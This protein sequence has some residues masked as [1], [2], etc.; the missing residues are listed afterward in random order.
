MKTELDEK[1][2]RL[3]SID[4]HGRWWDI[5]ESEMRG[6]PQRRRLPSRPLPP[7]WQFLATHRDLRSSGFLGSEG[8]KGRGFES[9]SEEAVHWVMWNGSGGT[10]LYAFLCRGTASIYANCAYGRVFCPYDTDVDVKSTNLILFNLQCTSLNVTRLT[11]ETSDGGY[12]VNAD[13]GPN[14]DGLL[15]WLC[16]CGKAR[17]TGLNESQPRLLSCSPLPSDGLGRRGAEAHRKQHPQ[18]CGVNPTAKTHRHTHTSCYLS[19][20][21]GQNYNHDSN[22]DGHQFHAGNREHR[23]GKKPI[24]TTTKSCTKNNNNKEKQSPSLK[25]S[26]EGGSRRQLGLGDAGLRRK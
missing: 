6:L 19:Y 24:T 20:L 23:R 26:A 14:F 9:D 22:N 15:R 16:Q 11:H 4:R 10:Q 13:Y 8:G 12:H 7:P 1:R 18:R 2:V 3:S 17:Y 5:P 25:V 21:E